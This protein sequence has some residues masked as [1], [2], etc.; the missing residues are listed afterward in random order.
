MS[1]T[2]NPVPEE[3]T[4][5]CPQ[6][7]AT[8][9]PE[10]GEGLTAKLTRYYQTVVGILG[11]AMFTM[12][13]GVQNASANVNIDPNAI[14]NGFFDGFNLILGLTGLLTLMALPYGIQF[15][16]NFLGGIF[17]RFSQVRF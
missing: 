12:F 2:A 1:Q 13:A 5:A 6:V 11:V 9:T 8:P 15:A 10:Q 17:G 7:V 3:A 16:F 4:T 14:T